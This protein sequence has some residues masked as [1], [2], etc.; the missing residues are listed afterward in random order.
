MNTPA[1][2]AGEGSGCFANVGI[3]RRFGKGTVGRE[4]CA[5]G[6]QAWT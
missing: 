1:G 6:A 3:G 5:V 4:S 2:V